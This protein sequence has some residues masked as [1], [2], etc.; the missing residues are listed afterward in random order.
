[1]SSAPGP[2]ESLRR[3]SAQTAWRQRIGR[4]L[5]RAG[6]WTVLPAGFCA[7]AV[8]VGRFSRSA[9]SAIALWLFIGGAGLAVVPLALALA[10]LVRKQR[11]YSGAHTLDQFYGLHD[12]ITTALSFSD[13]PKERRSAFMRLAIEDASAFARDVEPRKAAPFHTPHHVWGAAVLAVLAV[14]FWFVRLPAEVEPP[15]LAQPRELLITPDDTQALRAAIEELRAEVEDPQ[16]RASAVKLNALIE[17]LASQELD[18]KQAF[19]RLDALDREL[20]SQLDLQED[21]LEAALTETARALRA[22]KLSKEASDSLAARKLPDAAEHLRDLSQ[23]LNAAKPPSARSRDALRK[24]LEKASGQRE[25]AERRLDGQRQELLA[26]RKRLLNK[27]AQAAAGERAQIQKRLDRTRRQLERLSRELERAQASRRQM[28]KLDR[29]LAAAAQA[30]SKELGGDDHALRRAAEEMDQVQK[31]RLTQQQ[32]RELLRRVNEIRARLREGG[33]KARQHQR[34]LLRF[35]E[36]A[37][38][39]KKG[40]PRK[41]GG[42]SSAELDPDAGIRLVPST[43]NVPAESGNGPGGGQEPGKQSDPNGRGEP[44]KTP[45]PGERLDLQGH[46]AGEGTASAQVIAGAAH[47]GFVATEYEDLYLQYQRV[48]EEVITQ[49]EIPPG[50]RLYVRRY[51]EL[52]RPRSGGGYSPSDQHGKT[53]GAARDE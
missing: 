23:K 3:L 31:E 34:R 41:S 19:R 32:K 1:M 20:Q 13:T 14:S 49:D 4:V 2:I 30:L 15:L 40:G 25:A 12:R 46:Q 38:G 26:Q 11:K 24:A 37:R 22:A 16:L 36:Q 44:T 21:A 9:D 5:R 39:G 47:Q 18:D 6:P 29:Q 17:Q 10:E 48:A 42:Q 8:I 43:E 51:F 35:G 50:Y 53:E 7:L 33:A 27:K 52:I 45:E 28:S